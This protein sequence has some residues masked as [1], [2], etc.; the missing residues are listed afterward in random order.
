MSAASA[1]KTDDKQAT[2]EMEIKALCTILKAEC[3]RFEEDHPS[4]QPPLRFTIA[5]RGTITYSLCAV[6]ETLSD[7][8]FT[9]NAT[10]MYEKI[11]DLQKDDPTKLHGFVYTVEQDSHQPKDDQPH[12]KPH[13]Q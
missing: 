13:T 12:S 4:V 9:E 2:D 1:P 8:N 10:K 5:Y 3:V 11:R 7:E 6:L